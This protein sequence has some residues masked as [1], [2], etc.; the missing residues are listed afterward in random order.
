L[1]ILLILLFF[2]I[3]YLYFLAKK[4]MGAGG[5]YPSHTNPYDNMGYNRPYYNQG[6]YSPPGHIPAY[7]YPP[8]TGMGF[9][10]GFQ[11]P[12]SPMQYGPTMNGF[13]PGLFS[14][15]IGGRGFF[16]S[17]RAASGG[18][19]SAPPSGTQNGNIQL[20]RPGAHRPHFDEQ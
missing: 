11:R 14:N 17:P 20:N 12:Y 5:M 7:G 3:Y 9:G 10:R 6:G 15:Q 1:F 8:Y 16:N 2:Y 18:L 13:Q 19:Q 4:T